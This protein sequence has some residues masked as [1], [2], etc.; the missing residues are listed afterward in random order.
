VQNLTLNRMV[1]FSD[2][3]VHQKMA[4]HYE[5]LTFP[6]FFAKYS[7]AGFAILSELSIKAV[8]LDVELNSASNNTI[9]T[10]IT[11]KKISMRVK[12]EGHRR[13]NAILR[14]KWFCSMILVKNSIIR[15]RI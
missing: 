8:Q 6:D 14:M 11:E 13:A 15:R 3:V 10:R 12:A 2:Q 5:I 7:A 4:L 1:I 9:F